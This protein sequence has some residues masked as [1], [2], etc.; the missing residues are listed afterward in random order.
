ML[1]GAILLLERCNIDVAVGDRAVIALE[2]D[3]TG[4][5][6]PADHARGGGAL[7]LDVLVEYLAIEFHDQEPGIGG[8]LAASLGLK[9]FKV[10]GIAALLLILKKAWFIIFIPFVFAWGW[11]KRLFSRNN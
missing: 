1:F 8:L 2:H 6:F 10:G 11:I 9:A 5:G 4:G 7:H 3:G